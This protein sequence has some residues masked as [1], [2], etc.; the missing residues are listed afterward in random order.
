M[1]LY[2]GSRNYKPDGFL[3]VDIDP[4]HQPDI[5]ADVTDLASIADGS[6]EEI[7]ASHIL[8]HLPWPIAFKALAEWARVLRMGGILRLGVPDL[9][10]IAAMIVAGENPWSATGL[11]YGVGRLENSF[12][13]HQYGYTRAML[14]SI[15]RVLGF[16][17]FDWWKHD[18]PDASNGWMFAEDNGRVAISLNIA[19][20]KQRAPLVPTDA[21]LA[22]L[23]ANRMRPFDQVAAELLAAQPALPAEVEDDALLTQRLHM[24]LIDARMRIKMLEEPP[25]R[26]LYRGLNLVQ[27]YW[28]RR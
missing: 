16:G 28:V 5:I 26:K 23:T 3:T 22:A 6:V 4:T 27:R 17:A 15:L 20:R 2:L 1:K 18:M 14:L 25:L 7:C 12:E 13:A 24:A 11:L 19:A 8:E 9:G 21:L 10:A